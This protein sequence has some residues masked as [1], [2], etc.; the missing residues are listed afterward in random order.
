M[1]VLLCILLV[2][3]STLSAPVEARGTKLKFASVGT[4]NALL[5]RGM[6]AFQERKDLLIESVRLRNTNITIE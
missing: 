6:P 5:G 1:I 2:D 4:F 3:M